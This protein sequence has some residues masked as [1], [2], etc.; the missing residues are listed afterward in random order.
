MKIVMMMV[1]VIVLVFGIV[2]AIVSVIVFVFGALWKE[3][4]AGAFGKHA[5]K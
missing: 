5:T 4:L 2:T 3:P 1:A